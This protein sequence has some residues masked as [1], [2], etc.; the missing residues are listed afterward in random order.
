MELINKILNFM[1]TFEKI[2]MLRRVFVTEW[3]LQNVRKPTFSTSSFTYS[4]RIL[5]EFV[6]V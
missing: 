6:A 2:C 3:I 4:T 1:T 5:T